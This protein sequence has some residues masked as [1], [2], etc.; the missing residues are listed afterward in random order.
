MV[1]WQIGQPVSK[2][3]SGSR[4]SV[5]VNLLFNLRSP[6]KLAI[7]ASQHINIPY[8]LAFSVGSLSLRFPVAW[9]SALEVIVACCPLACVQDSIASLPMNAGTRLCASTH[10]S[11]P[12][13]IT[14]S[15]SV[16]PLELI[17]KFA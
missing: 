5:D 8:P 1:E 6:D 13:H 16:L 17:K 14:H 2:A 15:C 10:L 12:V 3:L 7:V 11:K 4:F 9:A